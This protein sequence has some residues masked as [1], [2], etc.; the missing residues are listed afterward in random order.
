MDFDLSTVAQKPVISA[1]LEYTETVD[2]A[3]SIE[4]ELRGNSCIRTKL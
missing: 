1:L 2:A 4:A 3:K